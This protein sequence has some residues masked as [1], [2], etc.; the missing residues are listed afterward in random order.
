[1]PQIALANFPSVICRCHFFIEIVSIKR[2]M[3]LTQ[4]RLY[5]SFSDLFPLPPLYQT[6]LLKSNPEKN[7]YIN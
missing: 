6:N 3:I 1:M 7:N 4:D 2:K 5:L